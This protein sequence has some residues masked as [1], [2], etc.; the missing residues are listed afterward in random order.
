MNR[1]KRA[2][3]I[4]IHGETDSEVKLVEEL[5]YAEKALVGFTGMHMY[6][7]VCPSEVFVGNTMPEVLRI[8]DVISRH[9]LS[10]GVIRAPQRGP[11]GIW[12][13]SHESD[14]RL[15]NGFIPELWGPCNCG[16]DGPARQFLWKALHGFK[17]GG[18][19]WFGGDHKDDCQ[20]YQTW[21]SGRRPCSCGADITILQ[22]YGSFLGRLFYTVIGYR[23]TSDP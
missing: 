13:N 11:L 5:E 4:L 1:L 19:W 17:I 22:K 18:K 3:Q 15:G 21:F 6:D 20:V 2:W 12:F 7:G 23:Q 9:T 8:Q 16:H 10:S 14:C